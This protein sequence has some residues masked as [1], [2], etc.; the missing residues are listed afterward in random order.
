MGPPCQQK[1]FFF[2]KKSEGTGDGDLPCL[3]KLLRCGG[4]DCRILRKGGLSGMRALPVFHTWN[5]APFFKNNS[6][7]PGPAVW[8]GVPE[9]PPCPVF[10]RT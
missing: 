3:Q 1:I 6:D 7:A 5:N 10:R 8:Q 9:S 2:L 4:R